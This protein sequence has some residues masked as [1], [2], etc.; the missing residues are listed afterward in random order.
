MTGNRKGSWKKKKNSLSHFGSKTICG[1][2]VHLVKFLMLPRTQLWNPLVSKHPGIIS[3]IRTKGKPNIVIAAKETRF[4]PPLH[5]IAQRAKCQQEKAAEDEM[6]HF[7]QNAFYAE[8]PHQR[9]YRRGKIICSIYIKITG[10]MCYSTGK[11]QLSGTKLS[12]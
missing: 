12:L 5:M 6:C 7:Q 8:Y 2:L 9:M 1:F 3:E 11:P 4:V 10:K